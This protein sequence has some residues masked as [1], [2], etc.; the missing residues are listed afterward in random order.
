MPVNAKHH[1]KCEEGIAPK[2]TP[3]FRA[4]GRQQN[5]ADAGLNQGAVVVAM[6]NPRDDAL[7]ARLKRAHEPEFIFT[8]D[9]A[10]R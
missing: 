2:S 10:K 1:G 4:R 9:I 6:V 7:R 3:N 5:A 8:F